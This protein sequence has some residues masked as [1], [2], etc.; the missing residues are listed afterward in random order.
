VTKPLLVSI[1]GAFVCALAIW[2]SA[3]IGS[4]RTAAL[5][6]LKTIDLAAAEHAVNRLPGDAEV[7]AA[8]GLLLQRTENYAE[9]CGEFERAIQLR[10]R[11]Y[12]LWMILGVTRDLNG[13]QAGGVAAL[14]ESLAR[15]PS[16]AK[17]RWLIGNLL[18]RTGEIDEAFQQL[19][20]A[21]ESNG[22]LTPSVID[23]AWGIS[24]GDAAKTVEL[25]QPQTDSARLA[26]AVFLAGRKQGAAALDQY[27]RTLSQPAAVADQL[28]QRLIESRS[29]AESYEVWTKSRCSSCQPGSIINGSFEEDIEINNQGF[30]W[31]IPANINNVTMSVDTA[32]HEN[33]TKSLRLDFHGHTDTQKALVSQLVIVEPGRRY[34]VSLHAITK[35]LVSASP[36]TARVLD[37]FPDKVSSLGQLSIRS[38]ALGWQPYSIYFTSGPNT[39]AVRLVVNREDCVNNPCAAFGTLWLDSVFLEGYETK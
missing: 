16:Y 30:G 6:A 29:F 2:E 13:D 39:R 18:L 33:G 11:D 8:R 31:Q 22:A 17:P 4:A 24:K 19:R 9:A 12:F 27:R 5:N 34:R 15:A 21:E 3:R 7:H 14:R 28:V 26:L 23:L 20:T 38:D 35:S 32:E 10:P 1:V 36:L 37:A 25:I